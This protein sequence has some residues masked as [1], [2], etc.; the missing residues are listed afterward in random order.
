ML[1][2][3][4][5]LSAG[6]AKR[7]HADEFENAREN[8]YTAG[9]RIVGQWH[10]RLA[11]RWGLRGEVRAEQFQRLAEGQHP[12]SGEQ[13]V[14]HQ[15]AHRSANARGET[16]T[17]ME[18]RA[19]W[20]ATFSAP[21][22]VSLTAL[23]GGDARVREAHRESVAV[24]LN[25][26]ERYTQARLGGNTPAET[27]GQSVAAT[28]E[29]DSARPV[30]GYAAP[31]LHTHAVIF[32]LTETAQGDIR[33][34]QPRELYKTQQYATAVYRSELAARLTALGYDIERGKS[35]QP[36]I[37][38]YSREYLDAS[39]PRR[40][41][42]EDYLAR[43]EQRGAAA[44][45]IAAHQTRDAKRELSADLVLEQHRQMA[46]AFGGQPMR[47]VTAAHAHTSLHAPEQPRTTA[48]AAMTFAQDRNLEREAVVDERAL[49]R[50]ALTRSMGEHTLAELQGEL[51]RRVEAGEVLSVEQ[52]PGAPG[53]AFTTP[54]MQE[55]ERDTIAIMR[56][57]QHT[58]RPL[59]TSDI[60]GAIERDHAHLSESQRAA[61]QQILT[62][63][64]Q[65]VALE[66]I[67]GAG[68]TTALSAVRD[69]AERAGYIVE[70]FAPT[71][72]AA[73]QLNETGIPST[74]LQ[75]HLSW[76]NE[77]HDQHP[78]Y[79]VLDE[80]SLTSTRQMNAFLHRLDA[81]DR[82]LLVGDVRQHQSIEAGRP[83][84]QLQEAGIA[85]ARL[86]DIVRQRDPELKA[87][88]EHLSRGEVTKAI[89]QL[90][91]QGRVHEIP[92]RAERFQ[93]I[94]HEY[95]RHPDGT[96]VVSPD[97]ESRTALNQVI[98]HARQEGGQVDRQEHQTRVL[99]PRQDMTGADRRWA[100][101]YEP[102][103][104]LRYTKGSEPLGLRPGDYARV[105]RTNA[106]SNL[107]TVAREDG[108]RITYD[109]RRLQG[110]TIYREAERALSNG[111]RVQFTAPDRALH[112]ANRE[113]GTIEAI[114]ASGDLRLRL[115]SGRAVAF[116]VKDHPHLDYGYAVTSYSGQGQTTDRVLVQVETA[117]ASE[118]LV[119]Q[120]MAYVALSRGRHDAQIYTDSHADLARA[121]GREV[122]HA[123]A[124]ERAVGSELGMSR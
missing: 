35:G 120:R 86:T 36:E 77:R 90:E 112:V 107:L 11:D 100:E 43:A 67:A 70:G 14:R 118:N 92:N 12:D 29:H 44:A 49:M 75:R 115:D 79:Y 113:L 3:S 56:A 38:G 108:E 62:S 58:Q 24:A 10:G 68:K 76:R 95:S 116:N 110:V 26:L 52:G 117:R 55:I 15:T 82:V 34:L 71:S 59:G 46:D 54:A 17:T 101:R 105:E 45:Q 121:L 48:R 91:A 4:K 31:Q 63:R 98:H 33:P 72:R 85:T 122:S 1:T 30:N 39:S 119:N 104:V 73:H 7:Y 109:P 106:T 87:I 8:Y 9:D 111:D 5:P 89:D 57:G 88:V 81:N 78:R 47:V 123:S 69:T 93:R 99:V 40:Q 61:V 13:L 6:Q 50:D 16:T 20:D 19:G 23:V 66:G 32:N 28:F 51:A 22:S 2:I 37:V 102:G 94:A 84:E 103:D 124:I 74:T 25:E 96:L 64:D 21:K 53:R 60:A 65:V 83:Y 80:S 42:I 41:Q 114:D 97:N 27:T 18:H